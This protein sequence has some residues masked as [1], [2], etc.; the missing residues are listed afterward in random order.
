M[1]CA[2]LAIR[3]INLAG[4][5]RIGSFYREFASFGPNND[6]DAECRDEG[7]IIPLDK[8]RA[9]FRRGTEESAQLVDTA[10]PDGRFKGKQFVFTGELRFLDRSEAS[11][12][13]TAQGGMASNS[14]S[15]KTDY[16]VVGEEVLG[17]F[18]RK[19]ETTGK[20]ARAVAIQEAGGSIQIIGA[21]E[22]LNMIR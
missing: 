16:L 14:V 18:K 3:L 4:P 11:E 20:L 17:A 13:V 7:G 8:Y 19:G 5:E 1:A 22:F 15:K 10:P 21:P 2:E 6:M 9:R 12:I